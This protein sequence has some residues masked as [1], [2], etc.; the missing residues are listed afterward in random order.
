MRI[1]LL[2]LCIVSFNAE[3]TKP[4]CSVESEEES[5][6]PSS[7]LY[8]VPVGIKDVDGKKLDLEQFYGRPVVISMFFTSCISICPQIAKDMLR[9]EAEAKKL[10]AVDFDLVLVS[11]DVKNDNPKALKA[12]AKRNQL[13][14]SRIQLFT[15]QTSA[16]AQSLS[17]LLE[18]PYRLQKDGSYGHASGLILMDSE[19]QFVM[20]EP[21]LGADPKEMAEAIARLLRSKS[22]S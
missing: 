3:E 11:M 8:Q 12:F 6:L 2:L 21:K 14:N 7:S 17:Q 5:V 15:A 20:K 9:L 16:D 10:G 19:G 22:D 4:C 18:L 1:L 13:E